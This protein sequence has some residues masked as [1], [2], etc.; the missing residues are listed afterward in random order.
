MMMMICDGSMYIFS[1]F[2]KDSFFFFLGMENGSAIYITFSLFLSI[3]S[4]SRCFAVFLER[5]E[6]VHWDGM[7]RESRGKKNSC[8][9]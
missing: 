4:L 3:R 9:D 2:T 6:G 8:L 5:L 1:S 7:G